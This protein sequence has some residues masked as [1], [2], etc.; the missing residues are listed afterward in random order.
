MS[1]LAQNQ[2]APGSALMSFFMVALWQTTPRQQTRPLA[3]PRAQAT[4]SGGREGRRPDHRLLSV[5]NSL[6]AAQRDELNSKDDDDDS[7]MNRSIARPRS[8]RRA[9]SLGTLA[10]FLPARTVTKCCAA[11][12]TGSS[13]LAVGRAKSRLSG[14]ENSLPQSRNLGTA[15]LTKSVV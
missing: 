9:R 8:P 13:C 14:C 5:S 6:S 4:T 3:G 7:I 1:T 15:S 11:A 10:K 2:I 12:A